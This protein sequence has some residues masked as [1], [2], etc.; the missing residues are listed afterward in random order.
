MGWILEFLFEYVLIFPGAFF[1][2][3]FFGMKRPFSHY[4]DASPEVNTIVAVAVFALI[5]VGLKTIFLN[6]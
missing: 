5:F 1:R 6:L 4:L 3:V 2:W